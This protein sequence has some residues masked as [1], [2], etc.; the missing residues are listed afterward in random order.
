[1]CTTIKSFAEGPA[2]VRRID[3]QMLFWIV[4]IMFDIITSLWI[5][6]NAPDQKPSTRF[7]S[8]TTH[9]RSTRQEKGI[10]LP[11]VGGAREAGSRGG[12]A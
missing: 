6:G 1:M 4:F 7:W 5:A 10:S 3:G 9:S 12:H 11:A 2:A 8:V